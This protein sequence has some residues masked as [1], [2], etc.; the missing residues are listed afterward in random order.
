MTLN[1][2][3]STNTPNEISPLLKGLSNTEVQAR[4]EKG[5][6]NKA[7]SPNSK[8]VKQIIISN[9][10]TLFNAINFGIFLLISSTGEFINTLFMGVIISNTLIGIIQEIRAKKILDKLKVL[11]SLTS[12]VIRDNTLNTIKSKDIVIDDICYLTSGDQ[13]TCDSIVLSSNELEVN[14]SLLTGESE[15]IIKKSGDELLSGSFVVAGS[16]HAKVT[17]VGDASFAQQITSAAKKYKRAY[18][19]ILSILNKIIKGV[20][21]III[22]SGILLFLS[23]YIR[24]K[25]TWQEA[26]ISSSTGII[27]MIPEGLVLLTTITFAVGIVKL[28]KK[29]TVIQELSGIEVLAR[30]NVLCLDKTGTLTKGNLEVMDVLHLINDDTKNKD[31]LKKVNFPEHNNSSFSVFNKKAISET[32]NALKDTNSTATA[33]LHY[34]KEDSTWQGTI[35]VPFSSARKWSGV[36]FYDKHSYIIGAPDVL[37]KD[38]DSEILKKANKYSLEGY[39]VILFCYSDALLSSSGLPDNLTPLSMILL[40]DEIRP[41]AKEALEFFSNNEV[42][43]KIISGDNPGTVAN[44]AQRL[45]LQNSDNYIDA[46]TLPTDMEELKKVVSENVIFGR[47]LPEQK[48]LLIKA[49]QKNGNIVAMTGDGVNDVLALKESDCS[50]AMAS[51]SEAAKNS[52]HI[53]LLDSDF[54]VLPKIVGEGRQIIHNIERVASLFLVKTTYSVLLS[55]FFI[56]LGLSYPFFPVHQTLIGSATIGIPAFFLAMEKK[57]S[58]VKPGFLKKVLLT[59]LPGGLIVTFNLLLTLIIQNYLSLSMAQTRLIS[60]LVAGS[61]GLIILYKIAKPLNT[62]RRTILISMSLVFYLP[63]ALFSNFLK[64]P[65]ITTESFLVV[66]IL[67]LITYP[68]LKLINYIIQKLINSKYFAHN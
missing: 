6:I 4:I 5:Q 24:S 8:T 32:L 58:R 17:K 25:V 47:V 15:P 36:T 56:I 13:I 31:F 64:L 1:S 50:I 39:R 48:K 59:A 54:T 23:Q 10:F 11:T 60:V 41:E 16:G 35:S 7:S 46:R 21:Y 20:T 51:G 44:V 33:L 65:H 55:F 57:Q 12:K 43:I 53:V 28:A 3:N 2:K 26:I 45:N 34:F 67:A 62:F 68:G 18:S 49:L 40:L 63:I 66:L 30:V 27:G 19:E 42:E 22:P 9:I 38:P 14:E 52:S 37:I 61:T 29:R